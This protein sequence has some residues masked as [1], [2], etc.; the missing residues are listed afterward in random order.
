MGKILPISVKL[1]FIPN[2]LGGY[3]Y[4]IELLAVRYKTQRVKN[5]SFET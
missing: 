3:G 5:T 1:N 2:A 4:V